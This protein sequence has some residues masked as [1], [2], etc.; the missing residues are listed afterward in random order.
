MRIAQLIIEPL[1]SPAINPYG[2]INHKHKY[3]SQ[4]GPT[5]SQAWK[6]FKKP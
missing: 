1:S 6:D 2:S 4:Q 5:I 3:Q